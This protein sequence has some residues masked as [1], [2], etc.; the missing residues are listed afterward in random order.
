MQ[1]ST[2]ITQYNST[3]SSSSTA[4]L[5]QRNI[6]HTDNHEQT[7]LLI[8]KKEENIYANRFYEPRS[9]SYYL[10]N[11][12][13]V[14]RDHLANE[15]TFLAWLRT[16]LALISVGVALTQLFRIE[17]RLN[18]ESIDDKLLKS[19][20]LI[21]LMFIIFGIMFVLFALSRYFH[22]QAAMIKGYFPASRGIIIISSASVFLSVL[23]LFLIIIFYR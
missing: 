18:E 19:G 8:K 9:F 3:S 20:R 11:K 4:S 6:P 23:L 16:S 14:A 12:G 13:S 7:P 17:R 10:E 22:N 5:H 15:R 21:G 2:S 1:T